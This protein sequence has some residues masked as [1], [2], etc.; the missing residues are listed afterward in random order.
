MS[1]ITAPGY[2]GRI[3]LFISTGSLE[4][5]NLKLSD[6]GEYGVSI[7]PAGDFAKTGR[8]TLNI[9]EPVSDVRISSLSTDLVEFNSSVHL[10]CSSSGSSL[11]FIWMNSSS[12][13]TAGDRVQI[14]DGGSTL[15]IINVTRYD[16]GSYRCRVFNP[17]ISIISDPVNISVS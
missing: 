10:S 8:I 16:R 5:R 6:S 17:V 15:T 3:T 12:D 9:Y 14:T 4:L 11:S 13:V 7:L 1:N 2:E